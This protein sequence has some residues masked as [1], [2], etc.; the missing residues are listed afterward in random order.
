[1]PHDKPPTLTTLPPELPVTE[2]DRERAREA[3]AAFC[4]YEPGP[5]WDVLVHNV[6]VAICITRWEEQQRRA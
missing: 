3:V 1:M 6:T 2:G 5:R 4:G